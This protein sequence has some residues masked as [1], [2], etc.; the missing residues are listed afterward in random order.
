V[1]GIN[2]TSGE[3][4]STK[5]VLMASVGSNEE[6]ALH[7]ALQGRGNNAINQTFDQLLDD[8]KTSFKK[9]AEQGQSYVVSLKGV[10]SFRKQGQPFLDAIK[11]IAGV[12]AV[13]QQSF[14]GQTLVL[15]VTFKGASN[16]LQQK[17]FSALEKAAG[18]GAL[19][20]DGI[21]GK[22]LSLKL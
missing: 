22:Q 16:E 2:A 4:F 6:R 3:V 18:F 19:D 1:R 8:L 12:S 17:I 20:V 15:D 10:T 7:R 11:G 5:P 14:T 13:K 21:S 9:T